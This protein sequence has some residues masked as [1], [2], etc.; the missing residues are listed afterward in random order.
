MKT[1]GKAWSVGAAD[2]ARIVTVP[3]HRDR[4]D[5]GAYARS[6][7]SIYLAVTFG[8]TYAIEVAI[9]LAGFRIS[10]TDPGVGQYVIAA[11]MW[12]P[13]AVAVLALRLGIAP[14]GPALRCGMDTRRLQL[15]GRR[16]LAHPRPTCESLAR[17]TEWGGRDRGLAATGPLA[18]GSSAYRGGQTMIQRNG[19]DGRSPWPGRDSANT[20]RRA[21][22]HPYAACVATRRFRS[23]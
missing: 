3:A 13:A 15:P 11:V 18:D 6:D 7:L 14:A 9:I 12:V 1:R 10:T 17:R 2:V 5:M 23:R 19:K 4:D 22:Q 20:P 8:A 21:C 16:H